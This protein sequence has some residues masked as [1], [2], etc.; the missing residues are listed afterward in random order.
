[1]GRGGA[2]DLEGHQVLVYYDRVLFYGLGDVSVDH[3][4]GF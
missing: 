1:V 4:D 3:C 2:A